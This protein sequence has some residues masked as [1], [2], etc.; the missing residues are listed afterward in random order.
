VSL[1]ERSCGAGG[2]PADALLPLDPLVYA[3]SNSVIVFC[4]DCM[5]AT[6]AGSF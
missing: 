4:T 3:V 6:T 2:G 1:W 5:T